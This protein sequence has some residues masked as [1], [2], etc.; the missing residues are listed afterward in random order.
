MAFA[1]AS[2]FNMRIW[3]SVRPVEMFAVL[4]IL[5]YERELCFGNRFFAVN[6]PLTAH[7]FLRCLKLGTRSNIFTAFSKSENISQATKASSRCKVFCLRMRKFLKNWHAYQSPTVIV[8]KITHKSR[9]RIIVVIPVFSRSSLLWATEEQD[10]GGQ[11]ESLSLLLY[12]LFPTSFVRAKVCFVFVSSLQSF[13]MRRAR[14][15]TSVNHV[16]EVFKN[17]KRYSE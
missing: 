5:Q 7:A 12:C 10:W 16:S 13:S 15:L 8:K 17:E 11:L 2:F 4:K 6:L 3:L 9:H 14:T 1:G